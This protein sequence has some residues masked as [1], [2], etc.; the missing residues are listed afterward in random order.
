MNSTIIEKAANIKLLVLDVDG[1]LTDGKIY[2]T[3]DGSEYKGFNS[4]D[5]IGIKLLMKFG[6]E[7]AIISGRESL[8][9]NRRM[10]LL[11][12]THIHQNIQDKLQKLKELQDKLNLN[13]EQIAY[14]GDDVPDLPPMQYVGIGIAVA[15]ADAFVKQHADLV[16]A[17]PGGKGA[18][19]EVSEFILSS[20]DKLTQIQQQ[21]LANE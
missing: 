19:R 8:S 17:L 1:V 20:Q 5:G 2:I 16:T 14:I 6:I 15:D 7:I 18:V 21:Y 13:P 9:V 3:D 12:V 4:R 11:G 10:E